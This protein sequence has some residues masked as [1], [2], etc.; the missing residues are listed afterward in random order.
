MAKEF[1]PL[2]RQGQERA[3]R[4][5]Q[6]NRSPSSPLLHNIQH[7]PLAPPDPPGPANPAARQARGGGS[8]PRLDHP[9]LDDPDR[10]DLFLL[11]PGSSSSSNGGGGGAP[12]PRPPMSVPAGSTTT[13]AAVQ[14]Q[15]RGRGGGGRRRGRHDDALLA[16]RPQQHAPL[17]PRDADL[18]GD[19]DLDGRLER[20]IFFIV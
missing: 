16:Q 20:R 19:G 18:P 5:E 12:L 2:L 13:A 15:R 4:N 17:L 11:S 6:F 8:Q 3:S 9:P 1:A 10:D 7:D 14:R